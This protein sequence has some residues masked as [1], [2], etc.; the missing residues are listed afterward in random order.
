MLP[1]RCPRPRWIGLSLSEPQYDQRD[2]TQ[3]RGKQADRQDDPARYLVARDHRGLARLGRARCA[4]EPARV[5]ASHRQRWFLY[6]DTFPCHS[7]GLVSGLAA[8]RLARS[9]RWCALYASLHTS[10]RQPPVVMRP[11]AVLHPWSVTLRTRW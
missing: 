11:T 10:Q 1:T 8:A 5:Q 7:R 3:A 2:N 9:W 4:S 6:V